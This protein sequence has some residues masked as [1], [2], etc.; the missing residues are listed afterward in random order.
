M[1]TNMVKITLRFLS[2]S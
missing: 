1:L 2:L